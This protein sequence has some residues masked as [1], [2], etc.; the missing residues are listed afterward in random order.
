M[1]QQDLIPESLVRQS[2]Y[3]LLQQIFTFP[4]V[5]FMT[6]LQEGMLLETLQTITQQLQ[7]E[8]KIL[9][10]F[11]AEVM[12]QLDSMKVAPEGCL[13]QLQIDYTR[14]F[15]SA[16]PGA[17]VSP[18]ARVHLEEGPGLQKDPEVFWQRAG[19]E[20]T[21]NWR[22]LPDHVV[23]ELGFMAWLINRKNETTDLKYVS[24]EGEFMQQHLSY[25]FP[26]FLHLVEAEAGTPFY[27]LMAKFARGFMD[28]EVRYLK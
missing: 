25:W 18:Y 27:R 17:V 10:E 22:E 15:I 11:Q 8:D 26:R 24:L 13:E 12:E 9:Q 3:Q 6:L 4:E 7:L 2:T 5:D 20:L 14:L 19:V 28:Y 21:P 23:V 16:Y 1:E